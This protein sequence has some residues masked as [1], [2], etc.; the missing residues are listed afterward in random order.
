MREV[1]IVDA[2]R[3]PIAR[4]HP[5]KGWFKDIRSDELGVIVVRGLLKRT[6]VVPH[7]VE[8]VILGCANQTGEQAMNTARYI[9]IMAGLPFEAA[10]QTINRQ[11][12][13]GM[14][15]VHS[16]A[17]AIISGCGDVIIAGGI[18]SMTHLPEGV[19]ADL[20]PR[21]FDFMDRSASSM[22][23]T[24][25]NL[26]EMYGISRQ[27]QEDFALGSHRMAIA[28]QEEGRFRDEII[29]V[30]VVSDNDEKTLIDSDQNPRSY[31]SLDIMAALEPIARPGGTITAATASPASDG[32]AAVLLM[33]QEDCGEMGLKPKARVVSMA[34]AGVDPKLMG[35]GAVEA[36]RK[37]LERAGLD[38]SDI[39]VAELN[40]AFAVVTIMAAR[41]LGIDGGKVNPNGGAVALGH[42]MGCTGARLVTTLVH[43]MA[44]RRVRYGLA[45]MCVG[46]GQGA[47]T[48]LE[49][50]D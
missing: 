14:T 3:T 42:P 7:Q 44:R 20:N 49:L 21:R 40:E 26:A 46:M 10:A 11:C 13:S 32:A 1:V 30:E 17:Q 28:A 23:L 31:T 36:A 34:V 43:E 38:A 18:E 45:A 27:E 15:A 50:A 5:E 41:E 25:E 39:G 8:D 47:A 24:A 35:L 22:G 2:V 6:G 16:A 48:V 37:A 29:P 33:A 12:A 19:G 4:A 9:A